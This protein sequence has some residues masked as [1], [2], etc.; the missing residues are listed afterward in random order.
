MAQ[1]G[2]RSRDG[3]PAHQRI[4]IRVTSRER[5]VLDRVARANKTTRSD[6]IRAAVNDYIDDCAD[7]FLGILSARNSKRVRG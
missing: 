3:A 4:W 7:G 6:V 2:R 1:R 5:D